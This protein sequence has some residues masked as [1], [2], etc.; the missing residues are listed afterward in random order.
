MCMHI[1]IENNQ[2]MRENLQ[3]NILKK[4]FDYQVIF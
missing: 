4:F 2:N 3:L 1:N